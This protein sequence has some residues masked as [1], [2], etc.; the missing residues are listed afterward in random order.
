MTYRPDS[1]D[2]GLPDGRE[3]Q[4][5]LDPLNPADLHGP[6]GD[7]DNDG[8]SNAQ[9]LALGTH[10]NHP[11]SDDDGLPDGWEVQHGLDP[12]NPADL[13]GPDGD[14]DNDGRT[15]LEEYLAGTNPVVFD[16]TIF[17]PLILLE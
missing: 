6:D 8:L 5:G 1:D 10:P 14:P 12:L 9:E 17:L 7:P 16:G 3:V 13:H 4:H 2:D 11:D 15:N